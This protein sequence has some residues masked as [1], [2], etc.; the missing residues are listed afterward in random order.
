M[1]NDCKN[2][3]HQPALFTSVRWPR[4]KTV[5]RDTALGALDKMISWPDLE[6]LVR[7]HY[8]ADIQKTGRKGYSLRMLL[9]CLVLQ[10]LWNLSDRQVEVEVLDSHSMARFI[11]TDPWAPRPPSYSKI[12]EFRVTL[13]SWHIDPITGARTFGEPRNYLCLHEAVVDAFLADLRRA[14]M[15]VRQGSVTDPQFR[16]LTPA[17]ADLDLDLDDG[18]ED[19]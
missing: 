16:R 10:Y 11:G 7:P 3:S 15:E 14:G 8:N 1:L 17:A 4:A 5:K 18:M 13:M 12:R 6:A 9:R 19:L 2:H